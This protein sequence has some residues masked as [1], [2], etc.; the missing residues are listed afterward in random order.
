MEGG[1]FRPFSIHHLTLRG[2][3]AAVCGSFRSPIAFPPLL[4]LTSPLVRSV[5]SRTLFAQP[6]EQQLRAG[7][8]RPT[9]T[10]YKESRKK[11]LSAYGCA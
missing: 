7:P 10:N 5:G 4:E 3:D 1:F 6:R 9:F 8:D 2:K 11:S